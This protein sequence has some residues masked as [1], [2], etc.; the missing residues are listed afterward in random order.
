[1]LLASAGLGMLCSYPSM[2]ALTERFGPRLVSAGGAFI[3]LVGTLPFA[4][5]YLSPES[6]WAICLALFVRGI[7]MGGI[8]IPS[9]QSAYSSIA[10]EKIP[11]ATTTINIVQRLGGPVATTALAIFLHA[12]TS[13]L[14]HA[15]GVSQ[16]NWNAR[17]SAATFLLLCG[18][19]A[20]A[21]LAAMF[22]PLRV[23]REL[24]TLNPG[25]CIADPCDRKLTLICRERHPSN[26]FGDIE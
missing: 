2:G 11:V 25:T 10:K 22:L 1:M 6:K 18:F 4:L 12:R 9:F 7:G 13:A 23:K 16:A 5:V 3:A 8:G 26:T 17:A 14:A 21:C 20:A 24:A 19:H 15:S